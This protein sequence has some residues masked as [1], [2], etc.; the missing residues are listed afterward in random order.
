[1]K[2]QPVLPKFVNEFYLMLARKT[3]FSL[4]LSVS[5][6][7]LHAQT[8]DQ[9][10][11]NYI[12]FTGGE[13]SWDKIHSITTSG[14]YNYGGMEFPFQSWSKAPNLY[15]YIVKS[16]DKY[17]AQAYDGKQGWKIDGFKGETTKTILEGE[18]AKAMA[19]EADVELESPFIGYRKK[20]FEAIDEGNDTVD[21]AACYK[22]KLIKNN[23]DTSTWFFR[24]TDFALV[25]KQAISKNAELDN[26]LLDTYYSDYKV[27]EGVKFP[28]KMVSKVNDQTILTIIVTDLQ[29]NVPIP[30]NDF[31]P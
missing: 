30:D 19:N 17:F 23:N 18:S 25:K 31:K 29:L 28:F 26:S 8:A 27:V 21:G 9:V 10:I 14:T 22:I 2:A 3:I 7:A 13:K 4:L 1:M 6:V 20:G 11:S 16:N 12:V 5:S 24:N 15:K